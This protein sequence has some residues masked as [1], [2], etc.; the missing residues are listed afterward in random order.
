MWSVL[1]ISSALQFCP[2]QKRMHSYVVLFAS[3]NAL[4]YGPFCFWECTPIWSI[5]IF[6]V[7]SHLVLITFENALRSGP[8]IISFWHFTASKTH[9]VIL[10]KLV[11]PI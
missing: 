11:E 7:H 4:R 6:G 10:E 2:Y 3:K 1:Q 5:T 9:P 8:P